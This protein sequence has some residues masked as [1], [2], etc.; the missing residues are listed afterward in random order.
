MTKKIFLVATI[1]TGLLFISS[2]TFAN[3]DLQKAGNSVRNVV[4]GAENAVEG[5]VGSAAGAIKNGTN[6]IG[7]T[8]NNLVKDMK[9]GTDRT[10]TK[11]TGT[12]ANRN[13]G[14]GYNARRT[15]ATFA[16]MTSTAWTWLIL[17]I[18]AIAI[19]AL[20]WYYSAQNSNSYKNDE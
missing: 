4:G 1:I 6:D 18:A 14:T 13:T 12:T 2:H 17:G 10:H 11:T 9:D 19:I 16:G 7:N 20:V 5:A 8:G 15:A 3:N